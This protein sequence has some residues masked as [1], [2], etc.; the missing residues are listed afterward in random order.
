MTWFF[1]EEFEYFDEDTNIYY[2][3]SWNVTSDE[4]HI[5]K[6]NEMSGDDFWKFNENLAGEIMD[7][8]DMEYVNDEDFWF[9]KSHPEL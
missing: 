8:I 6:I 1:D 7:Y 5:T 9:D 4:V 2:N 3:V